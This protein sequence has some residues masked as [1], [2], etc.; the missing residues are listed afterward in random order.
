MKNEE[1]RNYD[2]IIVIVM[3]FAFLFPYRGCLIA[4]ILTGVS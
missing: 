1:N 3:I 2:I 4:M